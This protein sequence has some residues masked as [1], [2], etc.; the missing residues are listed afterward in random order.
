MLIF[1]LMPGSI[2]IRRIYLAFELGV[3]WILLPILWWASLIGCR[4]P[5]KSFR[6]L[7]TPKRKSAWFVHLAH[8]C[9]LKSSLFPNYVYHYHFPAIAILWLRLLHSPHTHTIVF[10]F[11]SF[12]SC[13]YLQFLLSKHAL[14]RDSPFVPHTRLGT[15]E[16]T[17]PLQNFERDVGTTNES[18][19]SS[20]QFHLLH[21]ITIFLGFMFICTNLTLHNPK[22]KKKN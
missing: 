4:S 19:T 1:R 5:K 10:A 2:S 13:C 22:K 12:Y 9:N 6:T 16:S 11:F 15:Q 8:I 21:F 7:N 3:E 18:R 14:S 20:S 17:H